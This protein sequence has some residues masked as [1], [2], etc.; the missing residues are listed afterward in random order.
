MNTSLQQLSIPCNAV[1]AYYISWSD[2][3]YLI[4]IQTLLFSYFYC[5]ADSILLYWKQINS[6]FQCFLVKIHCKMSEINKKGWKQPKK[7]FQPDFGCE[8]HTKDDWNTHY[9]TFT[10]QKLLKS[11]TICFTP[12]A[13]LYET[14]P[15]SIHR[16]LPLDPAGLFVWIVPQI[17]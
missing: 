3:C 13:Q 16:S 17:K 7:L 2:I 4:T 15:R 8:Q 5:K 9:P 12:C 1:I 14:D 6:I 10:P 11:L